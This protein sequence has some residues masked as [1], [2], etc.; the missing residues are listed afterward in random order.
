MAIEISQTLA[1]EIGLFS[2]SYTQNQ[3]PTSFQYYLDE[4]QKKLSLLFSPFGSFNFS[5]WF[6]YPAF[7]SSTTTDKFNES[8]QMQGT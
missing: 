8:V 2:D 4:E 1:P 7:S 3:A 5:A 6:S